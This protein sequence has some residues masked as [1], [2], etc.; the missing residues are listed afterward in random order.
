MEILVALR[1]L[2][3]RRFL[4][5]LGGVLAVLLA[6]SVVGAGTPGSGVATTSVLL[7]KSQSQVIDA[8]P[9]GA[10]GLPW[11][12]TILTELLGTDSARQEIAQHAGIPADELAVVNPSLEVPMVPASLPVTAADAT[13]I[14]PDAYLLTVGTDGVLPLVSL[15]AEAPD[16]RAAVRLA[17]SAVKVLEARAAPAGASKRQSFVVKRVAVVD[18]REL[19]G[20]TPWLKVLAAAIVL[21]LLW[22]GGM[23]AVQTALIKVREGRPPPRLVGNGRS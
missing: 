8:T 17:D 5:A 18:A 19:A 10:G 21:F 16:R 14:P 13:A 20:G 6:Y 23:L 11:R 4:M 7:D 3:R 12:A 15:K 22:C 1:A 9:P 2:W